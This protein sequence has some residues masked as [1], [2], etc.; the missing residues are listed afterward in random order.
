MGV[1]QMLRFILIAGLAV[2]L[3]ILAAAFAV[4]FADFS[5]LIQEQ[6]R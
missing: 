4:G 3:A 6:A 1:L 2:T 5:T